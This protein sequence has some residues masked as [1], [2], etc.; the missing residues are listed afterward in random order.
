M[1]AFDDVD[2]SRTWSGIAATFALGLG[3]CVASG[4]AF[5]PASS[6]APRSSASGGVVDSFVV[7][8]AALRETLTVRVYRPR[9][10]SPARRYPAVYVLQQGVFFDRLGLPTWMDSATTGTTPPALVVAVP[11]ANGLGAFRPD[12]PRGDAYGRFIASELVPAVE[13]RYSAQRGPDG[14]LLL[15]FSAG[16]NVL[17]DVAARNPDTFGRV[18]AASPGWMHVDERG[19]IGVDFHEAAARNVATASSPP[20]SAFWFVWG[21]APSEWERRSRANGSTVLAALRARGATVID[22][23]VVPGDHGLGLARTTMAPALAFLLAPPDSGHRP[24]P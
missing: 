8:S 9:G 15:G 17:I 16:A 3:A 24:A 18:A 20:G 7:E 13:A 4:S 6:A 23:G 22:A 21:D 2:R 5:R 12:L 14:R 11:D 10:Y 19:A 1:L